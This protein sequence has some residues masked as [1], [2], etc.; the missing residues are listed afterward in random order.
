MFPLP[1]IRVDLIK[2]GIDANW[3]NCRKI[4]FSGKDYLLQIQKREIERTGINSLKISYNKV[5]GYY[6]EVSN[7]NKDKVPIRLDPKANAGKRRTLHHRRTKSLRRKN[8]AC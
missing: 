6:L 3:M 5:F 2:E 7:A 1:S 8:S 4:A